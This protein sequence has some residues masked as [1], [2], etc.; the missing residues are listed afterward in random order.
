MIEVDNV[1]S[2][3]KGTLDFP[4]RIQ[5]AS[6]SDDFSNYDTSSITSSVVDYEYENGRRYHGYKA[7]SYAVPNDEVS[8]TRLVR[9]GAIPVPT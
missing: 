5:K 6:P 8:V 9:N 2:L 7:G 4:N 3:L 1:R